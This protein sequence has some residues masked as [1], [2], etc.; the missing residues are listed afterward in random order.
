[1]AT[2]GVTNQEIAALLEEIATLLEQQDA[3]P[4]RV[5]AYRTGAATV[6]K[7]KKS[8]AT[9][10]ET[11]GAD[12]LQALPG[13][14]E[15]LAGTIAE[16]VSTGRSRALERLQG[17]FAPVDLLVRVPGI[18]EELAGRIVEKL[19]IETLEELERA[20]H[21][22]RLAMVEGFGPRRLETVRANLG[23]ILSQATQRRVRQR[24][25]A[26][27]TPPSQPTV[28]QLISV[29]EEYRRR[30]EADELNKIAPRR[31]NPNREAWLPV[32]HTERDE[33]E[34]T[35][36]FSNT[37]RAH[38]LNATRDWV[39]I[40]YRPE[41]KGQDAEGQNTVVTE[42]GGPL[43]GKRVIRG[44]EDECR[45]YYAQP[46]PAEFQDEGIAVQA[47]YDAAIPF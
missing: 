24:A 34:F 26:G 7:E 19:G 14:G 12:A 22:G 28:A 18:G 2:K 31:F 21:D 10:I 32:L 25:T 13:I 6:R 46:A 40:Y 33:W 39:V 8:L 38:E 3:N 23:S 44:R 42:T 1:M 16:Y 29:D 9:T 11:E 36:V 30:A 47:E 20:A 5:R 37:A 41:G 35:A 15:G 17:E 4:F 27:A 45:P 43:L